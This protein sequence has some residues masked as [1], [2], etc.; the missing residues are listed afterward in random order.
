M[1]FYSFKKPQLI[2][3][4]ILK[5]YNNK[6]NSPKIIIPEKNTQYEF[7]NVYYDDFINMLKN[8]CS[9]CVILFLLIILLYLRY[10]EV[11]IKKEKLKKII[12]NEL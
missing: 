3:N 9:F 2:D 10:I 6:Y 8:N 12:N 1:N 11:N 7:L 4:K 5:Y